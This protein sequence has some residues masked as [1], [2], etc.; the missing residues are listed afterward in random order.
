M[1]QATAAPPPL[2]PSSPSAKAE[3]TAGNEGF[4]K[5]QKAV[6]VNFNLSSSKKRKRYAQ[7]QIDK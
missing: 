5:R 4:V 3:A 6:T 1:P 7:S 2:A